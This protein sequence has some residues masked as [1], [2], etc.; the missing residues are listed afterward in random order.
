[1][2]DEALELAERKEARDKL[3][4]RYRVQFTRQL[5]DFVR[6]ELPMTMSNE[7]YQAGTAAMLTSLSRVLACSTVAWGETY[8]IERE[9]AMM[10]V[11][12]Q[13]DQSFIEAYAALD[14]GLAPQGELN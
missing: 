11:R 10:A 1:M 2:T 9:T 8:G 14:A 6:S 3:V 12:S 4:E 13:L 5:E 7:H